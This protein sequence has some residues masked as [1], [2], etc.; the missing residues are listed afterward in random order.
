MREF[1]DPSNDYTSSDNLFAYYFMTEIP[2]SI[3]DFEMELITGARVENYVLRL[4][5][6][7]SLATGRKPINVDKFNHNL[8]PAVALIFRLNNISNLRLSFSRNI[9][10]PQFRE[11]APFLYYNFEDQT[12]VRGNPELKQAQISNYDIRFET[13]PEVNEIISLSL[14]LKEIRNPI[15]KVFVV[16][17]GQNDRS[18]ANAGFARNFGFEIEYRTSL[19]ILTSLLENFTLVSNYSRIWSE[20]EETNQGT[21]RTLRPMQ[22]QSPYV[23]NLILSYSNIPMGISSSISYNRFGKRIYETA[24]F[25][26][27]DIYEFP[28]N[29]LD[30][31]LSKKILDNVE[32]KLTIKDLLGEKIEFYENEELVRSFTANTKFSLGVSYQL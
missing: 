9:N 12:Q 31:N 28:R 14:F 21:G 10:R 4:R 16:S 29:L 19:G 5:T 27:N 6:T 15:E 23:I 17:T 30:F 24:N 25:A 22:G 32:L 11:I 26:G 20:I 18:Y 7:S 3:F 1:Y 8:L 13:F 2:F